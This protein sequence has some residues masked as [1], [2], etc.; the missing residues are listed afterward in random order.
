MTSFRTATAA[1]TLC[2]LL[3][4]PA[5]A[6]PAKTYQVTGPI[7]ALTDDVITVTNKDGEKWEIARDKSLK[8][9]GEL[10]VGAKVT[11]QY[12]MSATS[13]EVKAEEKKK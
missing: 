1:A 5:V 8:V 12:R 13:V 9:T 10:K 6:A 3:A 7:I 2:A 4:V 11:I